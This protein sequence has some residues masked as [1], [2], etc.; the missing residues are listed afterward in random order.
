MRLLGSLSKITLTPYFFIIS[1]YS[2]GQSL[3]PNGGFETYSSL[4][5]DDCDWSLATGWNNAATT[6][7][8][9]TSN[10]TPDYYHILGTGFYSALPTNYFADVFPF[11]GDAVMGIGGRVNL[12]PDSREYIAI[13]LTSPLVVGETY[14]MSYSITN[15]TPNVGCLFIDGWGASLS[16]GPI[17]QPPGTDNVI[18]IVDFDYFVPGVFSAEDWQTY[19][20]TFTADQA[21]D[22]F[23]FGN[24]FT[25]ASQTVTTF[26][27]GF[28]RVA[29]IFLDDISIIPVIP[30]PIELIYF[31]A[32]T[33]DNRTVK[34]AWETASE[35]NNDFFTIERS[36]NAMDWEIVT[37]IDGA[38]NSNI[39]KNYVAKDNNPYS[40]VSYY[41]L[42]QTDF[43]GQFEYTSI[44]NVNL[45]ELFAESV[46][47]YPNPT[48]NL[49]T[50]V[51]STNELSEVRLF[52]VVGQDV[53]N[54]T[55][56]NSLNSS[57]L[58]I[59]LSQLAGGVYYVKTKTISSHVTVR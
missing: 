11:E 3:V 20:F 56:I 43:N 39:F 42:K 6:G 22:T 7:F 50:V 29:Y 48:D 16:I 34:L 30:L 38:G 33:E 14:I 5:N 24:F 58:S 4:P 27:T 55:R 35:I 59:D 32:I 26:G 21:Y 53:T 31:N 57:T 13:P 45:K 15:G 44:K 19:T 47:I 36:I 1:L 28:F 49:I 8:C 9:N 23:T 41:R 37:T 2:F 17:L 10:G 12:S 46:E 52:N 25:T 51:G 18:P 40:G 54:L